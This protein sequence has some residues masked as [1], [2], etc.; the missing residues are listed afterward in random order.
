MHVVRGQRG[1]PVVWSFLMFLLLGAMAGCTLLTAPAGPDE[2]L[3]RARAR[4]A[5]A[6]LQGYSVVQTRICECLPPYRY[7]LIVEGGRVT[8]VGYERDAAWPT[9]APLDSFLT[10][11]QVF[12]LLERVR[13]R[14]PAYWRVRYH[15]KYGY[16]TDIF[17]DI[18]ARIV[19]DEISLTLSD[20]QPL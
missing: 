13:Q 17:V 5:A 20:L 12:E 16:P 14:H 18:D 2:E 8:D 3:A 9:V 7:T 15:P 11:D 19:D 4:W 1:H 6:D 10:V